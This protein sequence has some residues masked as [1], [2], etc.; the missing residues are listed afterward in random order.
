MIRAMM[1][2][3]QLVGA[4]PKGQPA[5]LVAQA[6]AKNRDATEQLTYIFHSVSNGF[7]ITRAIREKHAIRLHSH[8]LVGRSARRNDLYITIRIDQQTKDVLLD[9]KV[10]GHH[11]KTRQLLFVNR[12]LWLLWRRG[13]QNRAFIPAIWLRAAYAA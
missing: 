12:L 2:E 1:A 11:P 13:R 4:A 7:G 9:A 10:V 5:K 8:Y 3:F 6:N